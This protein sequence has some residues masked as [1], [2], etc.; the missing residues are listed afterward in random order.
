MLVNTI[1]SS[2]VKRGKV[3]L[4]LKAH[5]ELDAH[6]VRDAERMSNIS[7]AEAAVPDASAG[8]ALQLEFQ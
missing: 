6:R 8:T 1:I 3:Q 2:F 7:R 4:Q 5:P